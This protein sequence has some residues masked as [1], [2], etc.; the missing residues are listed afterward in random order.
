MNGV[1]LYI[2]VHVHAYTYMYIHVCWMLSFCSPKL[3]QSSL[4]LNHVTDTHTHTQNSPPGVLVAQVTA[5]D[6]DAMDTL[7][8]RIMS[9]Q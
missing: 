6:D 7:V 4:K 5:V 2:H 9:G 3:N 1:V 8:Y